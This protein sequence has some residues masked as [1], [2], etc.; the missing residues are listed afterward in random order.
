LHDISEYVSWHLVFC[1]EC[2]HSVPIC[3]LI[4][5]SLHILRNKRVTLCAF[6]AHLTRNMVQ[7]LTTITFFVLE[8]YE[9]SSKSHF[10]SMIILQRLVFTSLQ[11]LSIHLRKSFR[12][13]SKLRSTHRV[14]VR[15][16]RMAHRE[17]DLNQ[18]TRT[19]LA[20]R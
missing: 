10:I 19:S 7:A 5:I 1:P 8:S 6:F 16:R 3:C 20:D 4:D 11:M 14:E 17:F 15:N 13:Q 12:Q 9:L 2:V 18:E